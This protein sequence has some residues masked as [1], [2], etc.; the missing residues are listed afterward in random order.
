MTVYFVQLLIVCAGAWIAKEARNRLTVG[1]AHGLTLLA[2]TSVPAARSLFVGTDAGYYVMYFDM[3]RTFEDVRNARLERG[4]FFLCWLGHFVSDN[5]AIVFLLVAAI[6]ATCFAHGI[7]RL[8]VNAPVSWFVL[9]ASGSYF[10]SFNGARQG[11]A[12][13]VV[14]AA[15]PALYNGRLAW[16]ATL[17]GLAMLFH[18]SAAWALPVY[19]LVR[20]RRF[21][22]FAGLLGV[23]C[24]AAVARFDELLGLSGRINERYVQ[25]GEVSEVGKGLRILFVLCVLFA[26]FLFARRLIGRYR[27][28][29][30]FALRLFAIGIAVSVISALQGTGASGVRRLA[31]YFLPA[32][33]LLWPIVFANIEAEKR[34][35]FAILFV[36]VYGAY[37]VLTLQAFG[38][39]VPY[40]INPFVRGW[41]PGS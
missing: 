1:G 21:S 7:H 22:R 18:T 24:V 16:Y 35:I 14:F 40:S 39:L 19:F 38:N 17:V 15:M 2:L 30:D 32:E 5:F 34:G 31:L 10:V 26:F 33:A 37:W 36:V 3:T 8:S 20:Q 28:F 23:G 29:Y 27:R 4:Y 41:L 13:A 9:I 25:Y 12:A 6:V 11:L